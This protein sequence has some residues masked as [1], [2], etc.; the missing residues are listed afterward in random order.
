MRKIRTVH[1]AAKLG[2]DVFYGWKEGAPELRFCGKKEL[3]IVRKIGQVK[4][5]QKLAKLLHYV[6]LHTNSM[7]ETYRRT[8]LLLFFCAE[9]ASYR[10][11]L[12]EVNIP[13]GLSCPKMCARSAR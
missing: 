6:L 5:N 10:K 7:E 13:P 3:T 2:S 1:T 9:G 11:L 4:G 12:H 8:H